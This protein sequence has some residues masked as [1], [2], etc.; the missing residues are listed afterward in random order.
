M[1]KLM[2]KF[3][4][5]AKAMEY[6]VVNDWNFHIDNMNR[7]QEAID[8]AE[9]GLFFNTTI[10]KESGFDWHIYFEDFILGVRKC[11]LKDDIQNVSDSK[12]KL[13]R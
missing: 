8:G 7:L 5:A 4:K 12:I 11:I 13:N 10:N 1:Y 3:Q 2:K 6:F 9:D